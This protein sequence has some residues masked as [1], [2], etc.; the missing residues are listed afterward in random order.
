MRV[1]LEVWVFSDFSFVFIFVW[2]VWL[3]EG[4]DE[5]LFLLVNRWGRWGRN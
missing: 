3:G 1:E 2:L 4:R 5:C